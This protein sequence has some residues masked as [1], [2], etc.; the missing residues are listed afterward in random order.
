MTTAH[1]TGLNRQQGG[2]VSD[3]AHIQQSVTDILT[4][5]KGTRLMLRD[6]GSDLPSLVDGTLTPTLR[7][8]VISAAYSAIS[9]WEPRITLKSVTAETAQGRIVLTL[10][11][12]RRDNQA[13]IT[14]TSSLATGG[15]Q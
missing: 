8:K 3:L 15:A 4:T 10:T 2:S 13:T 1:Y 6:Y 9:R 14:L 5:P 12:A 11:A 7:L